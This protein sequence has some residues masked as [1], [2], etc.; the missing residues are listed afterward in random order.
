VAVPTHADGGE[1]VQRID[2]FLL[3]V[4]CQGR[5]LNRLESHYLLDALSYLAEGQWTL[6][7][8]AIAAAERGSAAA[9]EDLFSVPASIDP[10]DIVRLR[11]RLNAISAMSP[12][13]L[14]TT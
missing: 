14:A 10:V 2:R 12:G 5:A 13:G 9:H 8:Q 1:L 3:A 4:N 11:D 6:C 7:D